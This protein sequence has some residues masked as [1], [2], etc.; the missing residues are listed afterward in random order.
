[1]IFGLIGDLD[2]FTKFWELEKHDSKDNPCYFCPCN[3]TSMNWRDFKPNASWVAATYTHEQWVATHPG[4]LSFLM[5]S[6][7]SVF[8]LCTDWMHVKYLGSDQYF[9]G[10][11][12]SYMSFIMMDGATP[13]DNMETI[14]GFIRAYYRQHAVASYF[15]VITV[16]MF[17]SKDSKKLRGRAA[18]IRHLAPALLHAFEIVVAYNL[19]HWSAEMKEFHLIISA[20]LKLNIKLDQILDDNPGWHIRG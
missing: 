8:T 14:M 5:M 10:S 2:Y 13:Q 20:A 3:L 9:F 16:G 19:P 15:K 7:I 4:R 11:I 18:E 12:L 6:F 17:T 1:M